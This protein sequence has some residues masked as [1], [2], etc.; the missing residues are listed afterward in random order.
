M[1]VRRLRMVDQ[2]TGA[3]RVDVHRHVVAL[4]HH[5]SAHLVERRCRDEVALP[6]DLPSDGGVLG[7]DRVVSASASC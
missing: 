5:V 7:A 2:F 6:I 3:V 4:A 1:V